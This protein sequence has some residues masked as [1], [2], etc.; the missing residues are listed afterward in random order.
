MITTHPSI[1][2]KTDMH[3]GRVKHILPNLTEPNR[4]IF[5]KSGTETNRTE[6]FPSRLKHMSDE[7][8]DAP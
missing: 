3:N 1:S 4:L 2:R 8:R 7:P 5:E 6:P